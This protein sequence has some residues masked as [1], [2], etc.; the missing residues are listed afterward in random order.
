VVVADGLTV[1]V[2]VEVKAASL[3]QVVVPVAQVAKSVELCPE[4]IVAGLAATP[5]GEPG[6]TFVEITVTVALA[7][8]PL[9]SLAVT[10]YDP[11]VRLLKVPDGLC[12]PTFGDIE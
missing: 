10:V 8:Q 11:A 7:L 1:L 2:M 12:E 9:A 5:V 4:Q 6:V 3:Y